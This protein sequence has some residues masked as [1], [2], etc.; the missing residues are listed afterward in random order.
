M[1]RSVNKSHWG[2]FPDLADAK[3]EVDDVFS[4]YPP[5]KRLQIEMLRAPDEVEVEETWV[6]I[7][8]L[9]EIT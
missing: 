2:E 9:L 3:Y 1:R 7:A 8:S 4:I 5:E 6:I